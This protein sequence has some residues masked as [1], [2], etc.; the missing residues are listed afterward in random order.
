MPRVIFVNRFFTP[1]HSATSQLVGDVASHLASRG[2]D[3]HVITSRQL[4]DQPQARL[5]STD[6]LNGVNVH[7]VATTQFGRSNLLGRAVDYFSFYALAWRSLRAI[8]QP[9]DIIVAMTDPPLISVVANQVARQ[10]RAHL[11]NWLQ[12]IY[13]EIAV[14]LGV[15]FLKG[16]IPSSIAYLRDRSFKAATANIVLGKRMADKVAARGAP[17][18]R[19]HII[20]NW[21]EDAE[22]SPVEPRANPLRRAWK[23]EN[24]FVVGYSG[25]LGRVH[26]Y[27]TLLAA[28]QQLKANQDIV[29]LCVGGGHL[30]KRLAESVKQCD[31]SNFRFLGYQHQKDLKFS[32]SV[33]DVHWISLRPELEGLI[34]PSKFY[35]I[36][37]A[38]RPTI[39]ICAK[40]GEISRIVQKYQCGTVVEPGRVDQL[41]ETIRRLSSDARW[42]TTMGR[43]ARVTLETHFTRRQA[44][45]RWQ[46]LVETI[47]KC[48]GALRRKEKS[49]ALAVDNQA[50]EPAGGESAGI[51]VDPIRLNLGPLVR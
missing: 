38:G 8:A 16:P 32:L 10:R 13:P 42:R 44:L 17:L 23:L 5:P 29:F 37:A 48:D 24:K 2:H 45:E 15:S 35:G 6:V 26:E 25:N 36:A 41:V 33:P 27:D 51:D 3:V 47:G 30:M 39:A 12:D 43:N 14:E 31:L 22:I 20:S 1:D 11:V 21:S 49:A 4:Y 9:G 34:V 19:I 18:R 28:A 50:G 46:T 7:R 40:D